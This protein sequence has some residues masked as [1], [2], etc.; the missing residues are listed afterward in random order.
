MTFLEIVQG[1]CQRVGIEVPTTLAGATDINTLILMD[2]VNEVYQGIAHG[3]EGDEVLVYQ[4]KWWWLEGE[5]TI[6]LFPTYRTGTVSGD[7]GGSS[8]TFVD[9]LLQTAGVQAGDRIQRVGDTAYFNLATVDSETSATIA[10]DLPQAW[11]TGSNFRIVRPYYLLPTDFSRTR[12]EVLYPEQGG[13]IHARPWD[14]YQ[15]RIA[16]RGQP[17]AEGSPKR[18]SIY[19]TTSGRRHVWFDRSPDRAYNVVFP[20]T[21]EITELA[22]DADVPLVP[23]KYHRVFIFGTAARFLMEVLDDTGGAVYE[24][25]YRAL[26]AAMVSDGDQA[27]TGDV[28]L[29]PS[30]DAYRA[31]MD[32]LGGHDGL[33]ARMAYRNND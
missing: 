17:I 22:A 6:E 15:R 2:L 3:G 33:A 21:R 30:R 9:S 24:Q 29:E 18:Y 10:E 14:V 4:R 25:R 19:G 5:T 1:T 27:D 20:Y 8:L 32:V 28:Q 11:A 26:L 31:Q 13:I 16:E 23:E 12:A 7:E